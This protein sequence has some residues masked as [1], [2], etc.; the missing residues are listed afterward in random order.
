MRTNLKYKFSPWG[1]TMHTSLKDTTAGVMTSLITTLFCE[2]R[3]QSKEN[4][5]KAFSAFRSIPGINSQ[6]AFIMGAQNPVYLR[7]ARGIFGANYDE[8]SHRSC[9]NF[10]ILKAFGA[11]V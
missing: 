6:G 8:D 2:I 10:L 4:I 7:E 9:L 1:L 3:K 11:T 5:E